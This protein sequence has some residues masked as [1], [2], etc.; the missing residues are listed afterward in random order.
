MARRIATTLVHEFR[1][2]LPPTLFFFVCFNLLVLTVALLSDRHQ[3][4]ALSHVAA[5]VGALLVGKA[6]IVAE[7]LPVF[8]RHSSRPLIYPT[9]WKAFLYFAAAFALHLA[10]RL[11]GIAAGGYAALGAAESQIR[12]IDWGHFAIVQLWL[13]ILILVYV[14]FRETVRAL[15]AGRTWRLFFVEGQPE[16]SPGKAPLETS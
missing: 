8:E 10:E 2:M 15:G 12:G 9:L 7:M 1:H 6:V 14:A 3:V 16:D 4:S 13:A 11:I 5:T